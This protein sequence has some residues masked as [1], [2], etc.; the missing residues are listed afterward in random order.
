MGVA[1]E[2]ELW[3]AGD[4]LITISPSLAIKEILPAEKDKAAN[5]I[6]TL[7]HFGMLY[8][9]LSEFLPVNL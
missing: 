5:S 8:S 4:R 7:E 3:A 9:I 6:R 2:D 1:V